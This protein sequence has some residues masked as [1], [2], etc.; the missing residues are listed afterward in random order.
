M[1]TIATEVFSRAAPRI[2]CKRGFVA[3]AVFERSVAR[4]ALKAGVA[5]WSQADGSGRAYMACIWVVVCG[6]CTA[7]VPSWR[8]Y[9][10][11]HC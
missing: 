9:V 7:N 5:S 8:V 4:Q 2:D 10:R 1:R 3:M 6:Y 11:S